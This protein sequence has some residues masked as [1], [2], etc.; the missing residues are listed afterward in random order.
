MEQL[1]ANNLE[2]AEM[3]KLLKIFNDYKLKGD[4]NEAEIKEFQNIVLTNK[5][6]I[7]KQNESIK[8]KIL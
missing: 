4:L 5:D 2:K 1:R 6:E 7:L 8:S 3:D